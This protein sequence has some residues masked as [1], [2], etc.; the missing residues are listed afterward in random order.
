MP[1]T[2]HPR[3][4]FLGWG[5]FKICWLKAPGPPAVYLHQQDT[6]GMA[7]LRPSTLL[8]L[9]TADKKHQCH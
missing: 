1:K 4:P 3:L 6:A 2:S 8:R 9:V 5:W 7:L